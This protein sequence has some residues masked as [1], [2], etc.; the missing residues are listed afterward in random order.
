MKLTIIS[1][2]ILFAFFS[3]STGREAV[4]PFRN[5]I[6]S[7]ERLFP[8]K[9]SDAEY[10]FR[11]WIN[12]STSI[13]RIISISK[14]S[15]DKFRGYFTEVGL[16]TKGKKTKKYYRQ[17]KVEPKSGFDEFKN[18]IDSLNLLG[19]TNEK[20]LDELPLHQPFSSYTVE[21][22]TYNKFNSFRFDTYYPYKGKIDEKYEAIEHLIFKE[23][24]ILQYFKFKK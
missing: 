9:S 11:I 6:S 24:D 20:D 16:L 5:F 14:D 2:F 15:L 12:N 13:D 18:K 21:I 8:V 19:L 10:F 7:G 3:C 17:I 23:F 4:M 1:L 22:K